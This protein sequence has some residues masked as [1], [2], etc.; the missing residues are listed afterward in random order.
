MTG[1]LADRL[2]AGVVTL[3]L[4]GLCTASLSSEPQ[5]PSRQDEVLRHHHYKVVDIGTF[6]GPQSYFNDLNLTDVFNY[7]AAFYGF[8]QVLNSEGTLVGFADTRIPDPYSAKPNFCYVLDCFITHAYAWRNGTKSDLG[9]LPGG[10]SSAA[11]WIN[12]HGWITGNSQIGETD[13]LIPGLPELRAVVWKGGQIRDLGTLGGSSSFSQ[14]INDQGQV[15]GLALNDVPDL[16]SF[17]YQYLYC[18][19]FNICP[20][21]ATQTRGFVWDEEGG[22]RDIG[23]LG[24]P[25]AFPSLINNR[26]QIAGFS[27]TDSAP[28]PTTGFPTLHP[29]LWE[30]EKGMKDLGG[31]G[32]TSTASVNGLNERGEVVGGSYLPGDQIIQPFLWDGKKLINLVAPPFLTSVNGEAAWINETGEVAGTA[33]VPG[34]PGR[35]AS[36]PHAFLWR[37]GVM[38]DLGTLAGYDFS[39]ATFINSRSQIVGTAFS[40]ASSMS[41]A[42]LWERGSMVDLNTLVQPNAPLH[43][44]TASYIDDRGRIAGFGSLPNGEM[45][46][47]LLIPCDEEH[48]NLEQCD[49]EPTEVTAVAASHSHSPGERIP[50]ETFHWVAR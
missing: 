33:G 2:M 14:A 48:P 11:F 19:P 10:A 37:N 24:G 22:M 26:G 34:V 46:A 3:A 7:G 43:L 21:N 17:F 15:T 16:F 28:Q 12:S 31:L 18:L 13:P 41:A 9:T 39:G 6:G 20:A 45:H 30:T 27:Y 25:D 47:A 50:V 36:A 5:E 1:R 4:V 35:C 42:F 23:T 44:F 8:A 32:G 49:Y 38:T 40:C 29:F